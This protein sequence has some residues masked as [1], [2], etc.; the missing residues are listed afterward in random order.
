M[1]K[2]SVNNSVSGPALPQVPDEWALAMERLRYF[3]EHPEPLNPETFSWY[4]CREI[5][6]PFK[7]NFS[8]ILEEER[9][10]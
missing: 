10:S 6:E 7:D 9:D 5:L 2:P 1:S 8:D 4:R 3:Q